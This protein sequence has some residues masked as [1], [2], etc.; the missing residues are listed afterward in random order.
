MSVEQQQQSKYFYMATLKHST[1]V[2]DS[3]KANY[4]WSPLSEKE[5]SSNNVKHHNTNKNYSNLCTNSTKT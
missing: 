3:I 5:L 1:S 4:S 2:V